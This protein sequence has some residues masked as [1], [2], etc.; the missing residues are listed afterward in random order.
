MKAAHAKLDAYAHNPYPTRPSIES[1]SKG[2]AP[3]CDVI[4][5]ANLDRLLAEVRKDFG[6]KQ[7]WLTE[8]G[9]QTNPP[10]PWLG[11]SP[12]VQAAYVGAGGAARVPGAERDAADPVPRP[13][14]AEHRALPERALQRARLAKPASYA[15]RLPLAQVTRTGRRVV[16]LGTGAARARARGR[17]GSRSRRTE[18]GAGSARRSGRTALGFFSRH[19]SRSPRGLAR[20]R[21]VAAGRSALTAGRSRSALSYASSTSCL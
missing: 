18:P 9:Y 20:P 5:M 2:A 11:V 3:T 19:A 13:R 1:P 8:Y 10:D 4:S 14:R 17:T 16:A 6:R 7:I 12:G 15:F 21:L